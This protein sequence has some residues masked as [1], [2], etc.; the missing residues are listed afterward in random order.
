[1]PPHGNLLKS[2]T[3]GRLP[4]VTWGLKNSDRSEAPGHLD[5]TRDRSPNFFKEHPPL[6]TMA[7][8]PGLRREKCKLRPLKAV[9]ALAVRIKRPSV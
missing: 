6:G 1:M 3:I 8:L 5:L 9:T 4:P 2:V 7:P